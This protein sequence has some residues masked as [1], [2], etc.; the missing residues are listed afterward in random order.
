[1]KK[2][3]L[4]RI[5]LV[6][7][8]ILILAL[9]TSYLLKE[10]P[11]HIYTND[12]KSVMTII[13]SVL[14]FNTAT[15]QDNSI[16]VNLLGL[17]PIKSVAVN[18]VDDIEVIPGGTSVGV[19]L[20]SQGV[21]VVGYSDVE[22]NKQKVESPSK[23]AGIEIGDIIINVDG[24]NVENTKSLIGLI[25]ASD[26]D[27]AN[28]TIIRNEQTIEKQIKIVHDGDEAKIGLW[29]RDTTA[30]VGTLTFI[31][32]NSGV[33]G[34]LGHPVTDSD[35]NQLF[36]I[37]EGELLD[38]SI[39]SI[40]KGENGSPGELKGIFIDGENSIGKIEKNTEC[41]IFGTYKDKSNSRFKNN[42]VKVGFRDEIT[43]GKASIITT[44]DDQGPKEYEV[45][46]IKLFQQKEAGPKSMLIKVTDSRL[47]EKTGGIVQGMSGSPI[48]QNGKIIGAVTHVLI[49]KP[50]VGYGIY[51]DWM[52]ENAGILK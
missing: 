38:S 17:I 21:L 11:N 6:I 23:L 44:I 25:K 27:T 9:V 8:P 45:E 42:K 20:S 7:A 29:I 4:S 14:P 28:L 37:K 41:G 26:N 30:G 40:R 51:I 13:P 22:I 1:M 19:R 52:L 31:D 34:A 32:S 49:N 48:M 47:L 3:V 43:L 15:Y 50:D 39:M 36:N 46:I 2:R 16:K 12:E 18:K 10:V 5:S 33:F 35:T 24:K